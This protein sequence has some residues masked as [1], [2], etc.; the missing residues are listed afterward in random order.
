MSAQ[1]VCV[2]LAAMTIVGVCAWLPPPNR[3]WENGMNAPVQ[4]P[5][6]EYHSGVGAQNVGVQHFF[7]FDASQ[8]IFHISKYYDESFLCLRKTTV[9]LR[10]KSDH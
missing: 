5:E 3:C 2:V 8:Y 1:S 9:D 6:S 4:V 10:G 7:M